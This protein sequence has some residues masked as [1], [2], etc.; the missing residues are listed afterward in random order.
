VVE[1]ESAQRVMARE[2]SAV[3]EYGSSQGVAT[4]RREEENY[5]RCNRCKTLGVVECAAQQAAARDVP[6]VVEHKSAQQAVARE[7]PAV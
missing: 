4:G 2:E 7:E 1:C 3:Q 5:Q 6:G